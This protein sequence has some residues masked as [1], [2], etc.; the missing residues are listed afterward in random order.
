MTLTETF[1]TQCQTHQNLVN[2]KTCELVPS[3]NSTRNAFVPRWRHVPR[4]HGDVP[5]VH[6]KQVLMQFHEDITWR[7]HG[8]KC[9]PR[10]Q[11]SNFKVQD[12][13][14]FW[15]CAWCFMG[16]FEQLNS[17]ISLG[18]VTHRQ[19]APLMLDKKGT[20]TSLSKA[21]FAKPTS[22]WSEDFWSASFAYKLPTFHH[23]RWI[24]WIAD[25]PLDQ[26]A[27]MYSTSQRPPSTWPVQ[28]A[29]LPPM[30][31]AAH[32]AAVLP[33]KAPGEKDTD[34][35]WIQKK[36]TWNQRCYILLRYIHIFTHINS[37]NVNVK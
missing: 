28:C 22:P 18:C 19:L 3:P 2:L 20:S 15:K 8:P 17:T 7:L 34:I 27:V 29:A 11:T 24:A 12:C 16:S 10:A 36:Q 5:S 14:M 26:M 37:I 23:L 21:D 6:Q 9:T 25:T 13:S 35:R 32:D 33:S 1:P 4:I 30:Q 31:R